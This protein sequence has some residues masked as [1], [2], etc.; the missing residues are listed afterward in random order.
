MFFPSVACL[1]QAN[2]KATNAAAFDLSAACSGFVSGMVVA[3]QFIEAGLYKKILVIGAECFSR[4]I[5]YQD[6]NTS[7]LFGD[8]A[9]AV[10]MGETKAGCGILGID[11]GADGTGG[12][13]LKVPAGGS[14]TPASQETVSN[15][16][17]AVQ[18]NGK[19]VF[20][21]AVSIMGESA[22]KALANAGLEADAID[23]LVP[24]QANTRIIQS[25]A[26]RLK[27]PMEKIVINV[28][29]YGNTSGASIP[30]ALHEAVESGRV[31]DGDML[32]LVGF[33][34]GLTWGACAIKWCKEANTIA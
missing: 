23:L 20:K 29:K 4:F 9:G 27:M 32:M 19:E 21:F 30:I 12:E 1:V 10:V 15:R 26:K 17:H 24:H 18:M 25:A 13:L 7:V 5:D 14:R 2:I 3:A 6:R 16:L 8:G 28:D 33:G 34:A 11:M 31:K 22:L